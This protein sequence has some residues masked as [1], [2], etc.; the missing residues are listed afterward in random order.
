MPG[1]AIPLAIAGGTTI[2]NAL[3]QQQ[4]QQQSA[5]QGANATLAKNLQRFQPQ[6][7]QQGAIQQHPL[8]AQIMQRGGN[9]Q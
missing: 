7:Q 6:Q 3:T 5:A 4:A 9:I 2:L 8:I 1:A